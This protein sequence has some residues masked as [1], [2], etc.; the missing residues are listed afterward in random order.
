MPVL[1]IRDTSTGK[2]IGIPTIKGDPGKDGTVSFDDLTEEQKASLKGEPG[3]DGYTPVKG[4]DYF[5]EED[6]NEI[7]DDVLAKFPNSEEV[8]Y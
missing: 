6:I 3:A 1:Y 7:V 8:S 2:F 4:K 5:T